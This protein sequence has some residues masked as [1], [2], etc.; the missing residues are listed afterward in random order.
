MSELT[1]QIRYWLPCFW[2]ASMPLGPSIQSVL[3]VLTL[4]SIFLDLKSFTELKSFMAKKWF[5]FLLLAIGYSFISLIWTPANHHEAAFYIKKHL[6]L[7]LIPLIALTFQDDKQKNMAFQGF[8]ISACIPLVIAIYLKLTNRSFH[9][10]LDQ[11]HIFYNHIITG[12]YSAIAA[13]ISLQFFMLQKKQIYFLGFILFSIQCLFL[14]TGRF[15]YLLYFSLIALTT[16]A[17]LP[18]KY[19][20]IMLLMGM[21]VLIAG[22][23]FSPVIKTGIQCLL[24]DIQKYQ[25]GDKQTSLGFRI[26]FHAFAIQQFLHHPYFGN[27]IAGFDALFSKLSPVPSWESKPNSHSQYLLVACDYGL[28]GL[29]LWGGFFYEL[30]NNLKQNPSLHV[31]FYGFMLALGL[32]FFTDNLLYASPGHLLMALVAIFYSPLSKKNT[33]YP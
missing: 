13:F 25:Q 28:M 2:F 19:I 15:A 31:I 18:K 3:F 24:Q 6:D 1:H 12:F 20:F 33:C 5:I 26:Q 30:I 27:G 9:G 11:G 32:N 21:M 7:L 14:N 8:L 4:A 16:C 23:S 17:N 10:D 22:I 29:F